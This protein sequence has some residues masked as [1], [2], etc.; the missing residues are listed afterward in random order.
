MTEQQSVKLAEE[1]HKASKMG[2]LASQIVMTKT[3][4]KNLQYDLNRIITVYR[5]I[6]DKAQKLLPHNNKDSE[7]EPVIWGAGGLDALPDSSPTR[8]AEI[9]INGCT[10]DI[11]EMTKMINEDESADPSLKILAKELTEADQNAIEALRKYL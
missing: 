7:N 6:S 9:L 10:I 5:G 3:Q 2:M 1:I 11:V 4:D 8:I